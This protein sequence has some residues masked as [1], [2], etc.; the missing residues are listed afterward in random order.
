MREVV[1]GDLH[2][3]KEEPFFTAGK[4]ILRDIT[5]TTNDGDFILLL[6]DTFHTSKPY[7]EEY[8]LF[9]RFIKNNLKK[10]IIILQGNHDFNGTWNSYSIDPLKN[11]DN[12]R[13]IKEP[14]ILESEDGKRSLYLPWI[15]TNFLKENDF[16]S[17]TMKEFYENEFSESSFFT[18]IEKSFNVDA[19]YQNSSINY[20]YYHFEDE[21]VFMGGENHG[22]DLSKYDK[23][24]PGIKRIGGHVHLQSKNYIGTPYQTR[25]DERNQKGKILIRDSGKGEDFREKELNTYLE[26][27]DIDYNENIEDYNNS[28]IDYILTVKNAPSVK[29][30]FDKFKSSNTYIRDISILTSEESSDIQEEDSNKTR[31][32]YL[33]Q[34]LKKYNVDKQTSGYLL[35]MF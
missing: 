27:V 14:C 13:V 19:L 10:K 17:K 22:I 21:T 4:R 1:V 8:N 18:K 34:Y 12:V 23:M 16:S 29:S 3:R 2:I 35:N 33:M 30:V 5:E 28:E 15:S 11:F 9:I 26:F 25:Y 31:K 6:G 20:L 32:E 24:F 7:P